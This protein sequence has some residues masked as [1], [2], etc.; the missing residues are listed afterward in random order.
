MSQYITPEELKTHAYDEEIAM[1]IREDETIALAAIDMAIEY[2]ETKLLKQYDTD[3]IFS[4][5]GSERSSLLV[6]FIKD[7][8]LWNLIG[9]ATPNIDY[10]DKE[11]RFNIANAWLKDVYK[12]MPT[13]LPKK[14]LQP[15]KSN[16][17]SFKSNPKRENRY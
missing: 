4:K 7:I 11:K 2:A 12:G 3:E 9:L 16:S 17:F 8:A 5:I 6:G 1:I 15:D 10:T 13:N 14:E